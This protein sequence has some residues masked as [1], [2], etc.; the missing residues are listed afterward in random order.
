[1]SAKEVDR[2]RL[3]KKVADSTDSFCTPA[4]DAYL[5]AHDEIA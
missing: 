3:M 4:L 1:V 2:F 5:A